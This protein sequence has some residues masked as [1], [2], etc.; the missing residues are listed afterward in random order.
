MLTLNQTPGN[1]SDSIWVMRLRGEGNNIISNGGFDSSSGWTLTG[2]WTISGGV[3]TY[4]YVDDASGNL[5]RTVITETTEYV[6]EYEVISQSGAT[7]LSLISASGIV[8]INILLSETVGKHSIKIGCNSGTTLIINCSTASSGSDVISIDNL[9]LR[10]YDNITYI[11]TR[12]I[13]LDNNYSGKILNKENNISQIDFTSTIEPS[14]GAGAVSSFSFSISR[15]ISEANLDGFFNEYYPSID[16]GFIVGRVVDFGIV[17]AGATTDAKITWLFRARVID[18]NYA[19]RILTLT[20]FQDSEI[21]NK[22]LP[23][24]DIQDMFDNGVSYF[25]DAPEDSFGKTIPIAYG[26]LDQSPSLPPY[27]NRFMPTVRVADNMYLITSH[28]NYNAYD[29]SFDDRLF[30]ELGIQ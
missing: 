1:N 23:F 12:D 17:W 6:L 20:C 15:Y 3:A 10:K 16:G 22:E 19:Q 27:V 4:D 30:E 13:N 11:A 29:P 14:G 28:L 25:P 21:T 7:V 26:D 2:D 24:Y 9:K 8:N 5:S 18:Y